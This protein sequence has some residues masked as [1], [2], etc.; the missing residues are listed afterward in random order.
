[1]DDLQS[2]VSVPLKAEGFIPTFREN[3]HA[4]LHPEVKDVS[5]AEAD[6]RDAIE[7]HTFQRIVDHLSSGLRL[8]EVLDL[9]FLEMRNLLPFDRIG[10]LAIDPAGKCVRMK[11]SQSCVATTPTSPSFSMQLSQY[12]LDEILKSRQPC[13]IGNLATHL[14]KNPGSEPSQM[15][16]LDGMRSSLMCPVVAGEKPVGFLLFSSV[17]PNVYSSKHSRVYTQ[18]ARQ[19][20]FI[21]E[22]ARLM[23]ELMEMDHLRSRLLGMVAHDLRTPIN[24]IIGYIY[25]IANGIVSDD[26]EQVKSIWSTMQQSCNRMLMMANQLVDMSAMEAGHLTLEPAWTDI[27]NFM[28]QIYHE[29]SILAK[30]REVNLVWSIDRGEACENKPILFFMDERRMFQVLENL[31]SNA[32]KY[33]YPGGTVEMIAR[34]YTGGA[35]EFIVKDTGKGIRLEDQQV[36]FSDFACGQIKP[37][38]SESSMGLGLAICK[39]IVEAHNGR[40]WLVSAPGD[41]TVVHVRLPGVETENGPHQTIKI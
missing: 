29:M 30:T 20:G 15:L 28:E 38:V 41:G 7:W 16:L 37:T 19:L 13:I 8:E 25:M 34:P 4:A 5:Q 23:D 35:G 10:Y 32:F 18:I 3:S 39:R 12:G 14:V 27:T 1:M 33:S 6:Q 2:D 11:W 21:I 36:L 40:I 17:E 24:V 22:K 9:V 31:L 26:Q